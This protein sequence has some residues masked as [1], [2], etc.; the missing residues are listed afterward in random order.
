V[1]LTELSPLAW[2]LLAT[3]AMVVGFAKTAVGSAGAL[4][5]VAFAAVLPARESTGALLPLLCV[6][7][8]VAVRV[9]HRHANWRLL[10][11]MLPGVLPGLLLG[12][13][14]VSSVDDTLMRRSIG[15]ILL[16]MCAVQVWMRRS[17]PILR[18]EG[19]NGRSHPHHLLTLGMGAAAGFATMTANAAGPVTT[20]YLLVAG[21][22]MLEFLGTAA[23]FYLVVN[24]AKL[25]FSAGL[26]LMSMEGL[27]IDALLVLPLLAG[28]AV[29]VFL[30]RR[31]DQSQFERAAL[32]LTTVA[33]VGLLV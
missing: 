21:L 16:V 32:A 25:P 17:A 29:G 19:G 11:R 8:L 3:G 31:I 1:T 15:A 22:P 6:G 5:V 27:V 10:A 14:F 28:A 20:L 2:V 18:D 30:V 33:A 23:W 7:D 26:G 9:Y 13:W 24:A 4:A 12:A